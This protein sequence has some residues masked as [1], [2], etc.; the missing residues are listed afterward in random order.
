MDGQHCNVLS[1]ETD[2]PAAVSSE[3]PFT[4]SI[5]DR[6]TTGGGKLRLSTTSHRRRTRSTQDLAAQ[7][8]ALSSDLGFAFFSFL[9]LHPST[10]DAAGYSPNG[11]VTNFPAS[12]KRTYESEAFHRHDPIVAV[13]RL[14]REI[15]SWYADDPDLR[16]TDAHCSVMDEMHAHDLHCGIAAPVH[17]PRGELS[18]LVLAANELKP[19]LDETARLCGPKIFWAAL[20][21]HSSSFSQTGRPSTPK[22]RDLTKREKECLFWTAKGK[23]SWETSRIIG[24]TETTVNFHLK[25]AMSKL[26]ACNKCHAVTKAIARGLLYV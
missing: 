9:S 23:T 11:Y 22:S 24:R 2:I 19:D 17:G 26:D 7:L 13:G 12:W 10:D 6:G 4:P 21:S 8:E 5:D 25:K 3:A 15:F 1:H 16:L 18:I 20:S 14:K